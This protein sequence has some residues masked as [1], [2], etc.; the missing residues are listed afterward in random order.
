MNLIKIQKIENKT[1]IHRSNVV[2]NSFFSE[3]IGFAFTNNEI[4]YQINLQ[5]M[6]IYIDQF[7][8]IFNS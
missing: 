7:L 1:H 8:I 3:H 6:K 2:Y 4:I 5:N